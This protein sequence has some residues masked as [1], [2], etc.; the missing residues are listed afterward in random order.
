MRTPP[1]CFKTNQSTGSFSPA[2]VPF[3]APHCSPDQ[4]AATWTGLQALHLSSLLVSH[5]PRP[6]K[7]TAK[8][9][10]PVFLW[11]PP[12]FL[13][14]LKSNLSLKSWLRCH[15]PHVAFP[16]LPSASSKQQASIICV[17]SSSPENTAPSHP[18]YLV[19]TS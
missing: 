18:C 8:L 6:G 2:Q 19:R 3:V 1:M 17:A 9:H 15:I 10:P 7:A 11:V 5:T 4:P 12:P 13:H 16:G 14:L